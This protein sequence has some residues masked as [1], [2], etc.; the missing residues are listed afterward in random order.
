MTAATDSGQTG[1]ARVLVV[2]PAYNAEKTLQ[3]TL[4]DIP[5]G[6][7]CDILL[8]DDASRDG[9]VAL[10]RTLG[11]EVRVHPVNRGYGAN[12]KTCYQTAIAQGVDVVIML[13]P[14]H[15]YDAS[16]LPALLDAV[17][18][19]GA[20]IALGSRFHNRNPRQDGMPEWRY[21]G[22]RLLTTC[23]NRVWGLQLS[24]YHTGLRAFRVSALKR[25]QL[26]R[27]SDGF[28]FDQQILAQ[29]VAAGLSV[30][31]VP[32][33]CRYFEDASSIPFPAAVRYG[34]ET[35]QILWEF[36]RWKARHAAMPCQHKAYMQQG[37]A[38]KRSDHWLDPRDIP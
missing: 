4:Q 13:H 37:D 29:A 12:Q 14:D 23:Q 1:A 15:Q 8:V 34:L 21:L 26:E 3:A 38:E 6:F 10:A 24:E 7:P 33:R 25:L 27:C 18:T 19:G 35:L 2:L 9:T 28:L 22:N 5:P 32:T 36:A 30:V 20:D 16:S 11:L 17:T 31:E